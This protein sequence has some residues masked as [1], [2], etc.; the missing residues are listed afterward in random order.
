MNLT[1]GEWMD[2]TLLKFRWMFCHISALEANTFEL[3]PLSNIILTDFQ[4]SKVG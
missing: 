2:G 1:T 4:I 3:L